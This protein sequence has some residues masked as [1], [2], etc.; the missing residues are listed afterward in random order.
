MAQ[1]R[2]LVLVLLTAAQSDGS[3]APAA[4]WGVNVHWVR[5]EPHQPC[6][7][8]LGAAGGPQPGEAEQLGAAF[9]RART[10]IRWF[11]A[12]QQLGV[13]N[14]TMYER[15][16]DDLESAGVG[17]YWI[18]AHGNPL[19]GTPPEPGDPITATQQEGFARFTVAM[20][21]HFAGRSVIWELWNEPN[22]GASW[23]NASGARHA[24]STQYAALL[25]AVG[26]AVRGDPRT[27]DEV[28]VGPTTSGVDVAFIASVGATGA[29]SW[30][31]GISVHPY[32]KG[33]PESVL[34]DYFGLREEL[35]RF[36]G[37]PAALL[38][39]EW[40][41]AACRFPNG[42]ATGCRSGGGAG[43]A[44]SEHEQASRLARQFLIND[45]ANITLSIWCKLLPVVLETPA[46]ASLIGTHIDMTSVYTR[47]DE[48]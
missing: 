35:R 24:N 18:L 14:F 37:A 17:A 3:D 30:L 16:L 41:W 23:V 4:R 12:E 27:K 43:E 26:Q 20:M 15:L 36:P 29:L 22:D 28:L 32:R 11:L 38:S 46:I 45:A 21:A 7:G 8:E 47:N 19:Y 33:G 10:G 13:Y 31:D 9:G 40:G 34:L 44:V 25:N 39:G 6:P 5:C 2:L 42:S 1:L 48:W